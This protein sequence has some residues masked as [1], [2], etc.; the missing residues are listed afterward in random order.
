MKV[1]RR[2][3]LK[4]RELQDATLK[5]LRGFRERTS[6]RGRRLFV[7]REF[8]KVVLLVDPYVGD[9]LVARQDHNRNRGLWR[10]D[11]KDAMCFVCGD[12]KATQAHHVIQIQYGGADIF[13]NKVPVCGICHADIHPWMPADETVVDRPMWS[14]P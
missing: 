14:R 10:K 1:Q 11:F 7:V 5:A 12:R 2:K 3:V 6:V 4:R 13:E 9:C 8:A